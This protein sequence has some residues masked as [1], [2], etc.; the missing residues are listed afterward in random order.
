MTPL[1]LWD[2]WPSYA[3]VAPSALAVRMH[4]RKYP[5]RHGKQLGV[6]E[7]TGER[8]SVGWEVAE[9][10]TLCGQNTGQGAEGI[11][12]PEGAYPLPCAQAWGRGCFW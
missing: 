1:C 4:S 5:R 8:S 9:E 3:S 7:Q 12:W 10:G 6:G 11:G 2:M